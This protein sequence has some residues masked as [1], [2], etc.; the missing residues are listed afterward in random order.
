[1]NVD[2][3]KIDFAGL[4]PNDPA[5]GYLTNELKKIKPE[6]GAGLWLYSSSYFVGVSVLNIIPGKNSFVTNNKFG[7]FFSPNFFATV[8]YR[9]N[10]G[11]DFNVIPSV[12]FQYWK[13]Q[14]LGTHLNIKMQYR[15][16]IWCGAG[17]RLSDLISGYS[18]M[19]GVNVSNTFNF[20]YSYE[21]AT[22]SR[23]KNYTGNTHELMIGFL[24]GNKFGDSC[25]K[26]I[27]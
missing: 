1:M 24:L 27:W 23:L 11:D 13:P 15:D 7:D 12:M 19:L 18:A 21:I 16:L 26:N 4:D 3:E 22:T 5:I 9:F 17:Y 2:R 8:G 14:L 6:L 20:S 10:M 25:P